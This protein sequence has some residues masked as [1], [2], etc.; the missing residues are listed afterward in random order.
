M[1]SQPPRR[2][3]ARATPVTLPTLSLDHPAIGH[4]RPLWVRR[5]RICAPVCTRKRPVVRLGAGGG[6][7]GGAGRGSGGRSGGK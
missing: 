1:C 5:T 3:V 4:K 6:A 2:L 7:E